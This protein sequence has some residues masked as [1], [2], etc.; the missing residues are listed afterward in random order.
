M[1]F[2]FCLLSRH[3]DWNISWVFFFSMRSLLVTFFFVFLYHRAHWPPWGGRKIESPTVSGVLVVIV[4]GLDVANKLTSKA[5]RKKRGDSVKPSRSK[6]EEIVI[7]SLTWP[8]NDAWCSFVVDLYQRQNFFFNFHRFQ[9]F[10]FW[11]REQKNLCVVHKI[12]I[13]LLLKSCD[14][15]LLEKIS[16]LC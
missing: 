16:L 4:P 1:F 14:A 3:C 6:T 5:L 9:W 15:F 13:N 11:N 12:S 7:V 2:G 10:A 8:R